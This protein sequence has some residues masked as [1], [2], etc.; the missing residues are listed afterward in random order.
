MV[1]GLLETQHRQMTQQQK[2]KAQAAEI[3]TSKS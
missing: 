3:I 2:A 1:A